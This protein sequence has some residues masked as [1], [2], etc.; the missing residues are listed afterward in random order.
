MKEVKGIEVEYNLTINDNLLS[1]QELLKE[2]TN[3]NSF[4]DA[5][6]VTAY[7][8]NNHIDS[9]INSFI[10]HKTIA[11][12]IFNPE[13]LS[14]KITFLGDGDI[15]IQFMLIYKI[16]DKSYFKT[17]GRVMTLLPN[18]DCLD[19]DTHV[20]FSNYIEE[21]FGQILNYAICCKREHMTEIYRRNKDE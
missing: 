8:I 18:D 7:M 16:E 19:A 15:C 2:F 14:C 1:M 6:E 10:I 3:T 9:I 21:L 13:N 20:V 5:K 4:E 17:I 12:E 11:E